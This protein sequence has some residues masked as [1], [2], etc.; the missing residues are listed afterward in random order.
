[1]FINI[2]HLISILIG[3]LWREKGGME[4]KIQ[5]VSAQAQLPTEHWLNYVKQVSFLSMRSKHTNRRGRYLDIKTA[6][7]V[8]KHFLYILSTRGWGWS[9]SGSKLLAILHHPIHKAPC[10]PNTS[11]I[12]FRDFCSRIVWKRTWS[13]LCISRLT[14]HLINWYFQSLA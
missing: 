8:Q 7:C 4:K 9:C 11:L 13:L 5:S 14:V 3:S 2:Y 12:K 1:M 10:G 6:G